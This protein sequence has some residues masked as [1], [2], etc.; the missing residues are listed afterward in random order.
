MMR[1]KKITLWILLLGVM[2]VSL[3]RAQETPCQPSKHAKL[4]VIT[5]LTYHEARKRLLS[6]GWQ[7]FQTKSV[8][9]ADSDLD[10]SS[11]NG[12]AFWKKGYVEVEACSG[13]GVA[14]CAFLFQDA[15]GNRLRVVTAGEE[16]PKRKAYAK[17]TGFRFVCE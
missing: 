5:K 12:R 1:K 6:A 17:V 7:P 14:P 15:Y 2:T 10:I 8:N 13:T 4:P 16:S 9:E 11:G 3:G